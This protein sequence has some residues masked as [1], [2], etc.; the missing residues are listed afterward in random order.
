M[1][2]LST[3]GRKKLHQTKELINSSV[4]IAG[5]VIAQYGDGDYEEEPFLFI[6]YT[7][8]FTYNMESINLLLTRYEFNPNFETAIG[9]LIRP[10]LL[11]F[12]VLAYL[13]SYKA[14]IKSEMDTINSEKYRE[15]LRTFFCDHLHHS[16]DF[17]KHL[18][19]VGLV[20]TLEYRKA[21]DNLIHDYNPLFLDSTADYI[22][23]ANKLLTAKKFAPLPTI[24]KRLANHPL[25]KDAAKAYDQYAYFSKYEH[26]GVMTTYMQG[27]EGDSDLYNMIEGIRYIHWGLHTSIAFLPDGA[28]KHNIELQKLLAIIGN[29]EVLLTQ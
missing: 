14:D 6:K 3:D 20:N 12:L 16:F 28:N 15:V 9:L 5:T 7:E 19:D 11:D 22:R 26:F 13:I 24:F 29:L 8:R 1:D 21:I 10:S 4:N 25:M 23:P 27:R 17:L 2:Y 18:N